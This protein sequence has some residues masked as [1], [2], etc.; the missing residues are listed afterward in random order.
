VG[1]GGFPLFST[2]S[3]PSS[4]VLDAAGNLWIADRG[5]RR[6]RVINAS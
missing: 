5:N 6:I 3:R 2:W 4:T 1:D